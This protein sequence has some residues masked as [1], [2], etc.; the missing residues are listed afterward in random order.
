MPEMDGYEFIE[1]VRSGIGL[2]EL[3]ILLF[4]FQD[5]ITGGINPEPRPHVMADRVILKPRK[6]AELAE[7]VSIVDDMLANSPAKDE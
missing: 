6:L 2:V 5:E 4:G 7:L 3:P 1:A